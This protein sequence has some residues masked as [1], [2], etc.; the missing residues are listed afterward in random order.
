MAKRD[1]RCSKCCKP[2]H[3][4]RRCP[5]KKTPKKRSK[6]KKKATLLTSLQSISQLEG[7]LNNSSKALRKAK[8]AHLE[9]VEAFETDDWEA[10]WGD[11]FERTWDKVVALALEMGCGQDEAATAADIV[12]ESVVRRLTGEF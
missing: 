7:R 1:R 3:D 9:K 8:T 10:Y 2:G 12:A 11:I 4:K 5:G 6:K